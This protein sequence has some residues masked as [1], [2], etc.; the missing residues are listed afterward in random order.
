[1]NVKTEFEN[2]DKCHLLSYILQCIS[3][4][5]AV[6][7]EGEGIILLTLWRR[8]ISTQL[9]RVDRYSS[10]FEELDQSKRMKESILF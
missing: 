6:T 9:I 3:F 1:M 2:K 10:Y 4:S 8:V 5:S 7:E